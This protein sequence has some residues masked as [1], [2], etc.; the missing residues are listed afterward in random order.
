MK[1]N[2]LLF[3]L[4]L[5]TSFSFAQN[6][7]FQDNFESYNVGAKVA[8][9]ST[10][11]TTW[12]NTPGSAEDAVVSDD[13][14]FSLSKSMLVSGTNDMILPLGN[15]TSGKY[16]VSFNCFVPTGFAGY[17][18]IQHFQ[19][20]G[21]EFAYEVYF[22]NN[23]TGYIEVNNVK[24]N[25][26]FPM[27]SWFAVENYI[28][29]DK[30]SAS[31]TINNAYV[32]SWKYSMQ[33]SSATG[34]K[35][36]GG[37][38]IFA[39]A[40][41]GQTPKF[42]VDDVRYAP[43]PELLFA[44]NFEAYTI[45]NKVAQTNSKW[46]TWSNTPGS[47]EDAV[48]SGDTSLSPVKSMLVSGSNDMVLKLGNKTSGEFL[49]DFN[50]FVPTGFGG[51]FNIQHF[52]APGTEFAYE[53]YFGNNGSG[54]V[55]V[56]SVKTNFTFPMNKWFNIKNNINIDDDSV[57]LT[58][59]NVAVNKWKFSMKATAP[60]GT[61]QLG[62]INIYAGAPETQTAKYYVDDIKY[63]SLSTEL[64]PP[65]VSIDSASLLTSGVN[66][67]FK[68]SNVGQQDLTY[69]VYGI[70][71]ASGKSVNNSNNAKLTLFENKNGTMTHT[72]I[73]LTNGVGYGG[74]VSFRAAAFF[75][76]EKTREY[77]GMSINSVD[78]G[79]WSIP[80]GGTAKLMVWDRGSYSTP[81]PGTLLDT[82]VFSIPT[83]QTVYTVP[84]HSP[85]YLDGKDIWVGYQAADADAVD[86]PIGVDGAPRVSQ[87][88]WLST[89]PGWSEMNAGTDAN[90]FISCNLVGDGVNN[91][92]TTSPSNGTIVPGANTTITV[93]FDVAGLVDD[94]TY[95]GK[96]VVAS[97]DPENEY[98]EVDV[99]L[100]VLPVGIGNVDKVGV[101]TYPNPTQDF[102]NIVTNNIIESVQVV[103]IA[104]QVVDFVKV[105]TKD[106]SIDMSRFEKGSYILNIRVNGQIVSK[107]VSVN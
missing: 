61:K 56:N 3:V 63:W 78:V 52:E 103:N 69:S 89:G 74:P 91:W 42:Y 107:K 88:S 57:Q 44:D 9:N 98:K 36:L 64:V 104:G 33:A 72:S 24:T 25:F 2:F 84:L 93:S 14:A 29:I 55:Q 81:G 87:S 39:G 16:S 65:T 15:K 17:Y 68:I 71:P 73:G 59:N 23:G 60:T 20:P 21:T 106:A 40:P 6:V 86:F 66:K 90:I 18:N 38:N 28:N 1:K 105:N 13:T 7:I 70:Y 67:T 34:T 101:M 75:K 32:H 26:T 47:A 97:N 12:S 43:V 102:I 19:A 45:G 31:L 79:I 96:I 48:I 54:Y 11:W 82:V 62:G 85:I 94:T 51:Y 46:T 99:Q 27:N 58:V 30:D 83:E 100:V 37:M 22:T 49:V 41:D 8:Q 10:V 50:Y 95:N 92:I 77:A 76:P 53:V 4:G 5:I 80:V 35:Q